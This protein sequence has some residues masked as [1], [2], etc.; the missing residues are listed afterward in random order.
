MLLQRLSRLAAAEMAK[1]DVL[2]VSMAQ[3][4]DDNVAVGDGALVLMQ[5]H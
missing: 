3:L 5:L 1:G 4:V 2:D